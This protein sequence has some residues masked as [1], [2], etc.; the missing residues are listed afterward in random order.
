[1]AVYWSK[2]FPF[3]VLHLN[4]M[5]SADKQRFSVRQYPVC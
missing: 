1:M 3:M 2:R 5:D 4:S